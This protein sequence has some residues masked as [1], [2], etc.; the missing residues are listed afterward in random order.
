MNCSDLLS[1]EFF[2]EFPD[3]TGSHSVLGLKSK[4]AAFLPTLDCQHD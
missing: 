1:P 2:N 3:A 4:E